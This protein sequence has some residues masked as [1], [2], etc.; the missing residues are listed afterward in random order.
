VSSLSLPRVLELRKLQQPAAPC[1]RAPRSEPRAAA[2]A[3]PSEKLEVLALH[4]DVL[5][6]EAQGAEGA[7]RFLPALYD[8]SDALRSE[9]SRRGG[10]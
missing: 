2:V 6:R 8:A 7:G 5:I 4:L 3:F 10:R 1:E 9:L